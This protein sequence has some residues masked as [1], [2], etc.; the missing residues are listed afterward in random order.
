MGEVLLY[1]SPLGAASLIELIVHGLEVS[2]QSAVRLRYRHV[3]QAEEYIT[4][5]MVIEKGHWRATIPAEY[6]DSPYPLIYFFELRDG[7]G[8]AWLYPGFSAELANQ[9][10]FVVRRI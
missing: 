5:E 6:T 8:Q 3:N 7:S 9:P 1:V 10:Y 2:Q 4:A